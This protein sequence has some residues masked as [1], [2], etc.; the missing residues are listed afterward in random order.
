MWI[1]LISVTKPRWPPSLPSSRVGAKYMLDRKEP[2]PE[3]LTLCE[4][5]VFVKRQ[6]MVSQF[7][8]LFYIDQTQ[9]VQILNLDDNELTIYIV[10]VVD[11]QVKQRARASVA[12]ILTY[13]V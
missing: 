1:H 10:N 5:Y 7:V 6:N 11:G 2:T 9:V 12:L 3:W 4:L 13:Y 8:W